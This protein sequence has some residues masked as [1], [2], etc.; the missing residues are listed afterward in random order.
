MRMTISS[1]KTLAAVSCAFS[2]FGHA[3]AWSAQVDQQAVSIIHDGVVTIVT[4]SL[5]A[6]RFSQDNSQYISCRISAS[7]ADDTVAMSCDAQ[8]AQ[9]NSFSCSSSEPAHVASVLALSANS[10]IS[11]DNDHPQAGHCGNVTIGVHSAD[12]LPAGQ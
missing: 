11:I 7:V 10:T 4:G 6:A 9:G 8:D 12:L 3:S 1:K 5:A 2:L